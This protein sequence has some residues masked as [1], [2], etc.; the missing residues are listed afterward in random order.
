MFK[1][2]FI[3][4]IVFGSINTYAGEEDLYDF[5]WLDPDKTVY[6][7]QNKLYPKEKSLYLDLGYISNITS[8][9]Q[10]TSG[11]Q[12]KLGY[13][14]TEDWGIELSHMQYSNTTN[15]AKDS[16]QIVTGT[17]PF[18][19]RPISSNAIYL[20]YSP[21]YGKINTFNK[22]FYFDWSFGIGTGSYV[23][24]SNLNTSELKTED[25]YDTE[26]YTPLHLKTTFK[27]HINKRFNVGIEFINTNF[28]AATPKSPTT[29]KWDQNNDLIF[30]VGVS[31]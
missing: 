23:M 4:T 7:L 29:K 31:F 27:F 2:I 26:N 12:L 16:V 17:V 3:M 9:F 8:T 24:E 18:I 1:I 20:I 19:R 28:E 13:F 6:V 21:F 11:I 25:R 22:I 10:E 5:L 14:I 15:S 30:S